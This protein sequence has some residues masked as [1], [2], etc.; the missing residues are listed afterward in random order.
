M[1][2]TKAESPDDVVDYTFKVTRQERDELFEIYSD[3]KDASLFRSLTQKHYKKILWNKGVLSTARAELKRLN[4][5]TAGWLE[6]VL[7]RATESKAARI[8]NKE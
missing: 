6:P 3:L 8:W 7:L 2:K 1:A 4:K 5:R